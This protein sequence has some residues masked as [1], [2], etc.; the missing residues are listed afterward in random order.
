MVVR[1]LL[2]GLI[3]LRCLLW[4][5][6]LPVSLPYAAVAAAYRWQLRSTAVMWR[7]MR[8]RQRM[9][10]IRQRAVAAARRWLRRSGSGAGGGG[11]GEEPPSPRSSFRLYSSGGSGMKQL[12]GSMLLFMPLLLLLP[13]TACFYGLALALH[14]ACA[15]PRAVLLLA[16][17]LLRHNPAAAALGQLLQPGSYSGGG[18][19]STARLQYS[20]A[21]VEWAPSALSA[22]EQRAAQRAIYL[23]VQERRG[24]PLHAAASAAAAAWAACQFEPADQVVLKMLQGQPLH[25]APPRVLRS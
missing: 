8:G 24:S 13:T 20:L 19:G 18:S 4:A 7:V 22:A 5:L 17:Q 15:L 21:Q 25:L 16:E 12:S 9:P 1:G 2:H 23:R 10:L 6:A 3:V 14:S 11:Q